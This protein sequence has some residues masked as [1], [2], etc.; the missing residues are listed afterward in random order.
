MEKFESQLTKGVE[1]QLEDMGDK[2]RKGDVEAAVK[3]GNHKSAAKNIKF[4]ESVLEKEIIKGWN[5]IL[6]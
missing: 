2:L 4:L 3:R 6:P 5:L 1:F